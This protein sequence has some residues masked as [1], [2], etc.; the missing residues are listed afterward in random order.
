MSIFAVNE[1]LFIT[2]RVFW[3]GSIIQQEMQNLISLPCYIAHS[4]LITL[5]YQPPGSFCIPL[6]V[7]YIINYVN[8]SGSA[9]HILALFGSSMHPFCLVHWHMRAQFPLLKGTL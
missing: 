5:P 4:S 1:G 7:N 3:G 8:I 9:Q 6:H 2:H